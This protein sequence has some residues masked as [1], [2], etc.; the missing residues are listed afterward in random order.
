MSPRGSLATKSS[1]DDA[2]LLPH[3][4]GPTLGD[5]AA[6]LIV[7]PSGNSARHDKAC[8]Q[9]APAGH[10]TSLPPPLTR[11]DMVDVTDYLAVQPSG[12]FCT[13]RQVLRARRTRR[14][15]NFTVAA[16]N[17]NA[18]S[19]SQMNKSRKNMQEIS[20]SAMSPA[21]LAGRPVHR[22]MRYE[23]SPDKI[24]SASARR[25]RPAADKDKHSRRYASAHK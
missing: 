12:K 11:T 19:T 8:T 9:A 10:T 2:Y 18:N 14:Q 7:Q 25:A 1:F 17:G 22:L 16:N 5:E 21:A 13:T 24:P 20:K 4:Q 6:H 3:R 15:H 23:E